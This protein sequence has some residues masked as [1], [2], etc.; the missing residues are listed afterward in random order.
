[1]WCVVC[2]SAVSPLLA[3]CV[4]VPICRFNHIRFSDDARLQL[5]AKHRDSRLRSGLRFRC[6]AST[7]T[8]NRS[9]GSMAHHLHDFSENENCIST[10]PCVC[11]CSID[12]NGCRR[13]DT[14]ECRCRMR[15]VR[16]YACAICG[17]VRYSECRVW[18]VA[19]L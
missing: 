19:I 7:V 12:A 5:S 8:R 10:T 17:A 6:S 4:E 1:M 11:I 14:A 13:P 16:E 3:V 2:G 18:N 9:Y 15:E